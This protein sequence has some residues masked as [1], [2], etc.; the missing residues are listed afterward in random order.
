MQNGVKK[1]I[2]FGNILADNTIIYYFK[3]KYSSSTHLQRVSLNG[4][5]LLLK[6]IT[7]IRKDWRKLSQLTHCRTKF[8]HP[9]LLQNIITHT[10]Q[11]D[12]LQMSTE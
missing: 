3:I 1:K 5:D 6:T 4:D 2:L 11:N 8:L 10:Q 9:N 12:A 7:N